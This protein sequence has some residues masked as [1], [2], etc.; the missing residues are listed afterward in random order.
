VSAVIKFCTLSKSSRSLS[1]PRLKTERRVFILATI[2]HF[3]DDIAVRQATETAQ[4]SSD[5]PKEEHTS[6]TETDQEESVEFEIDVDTPCCGP[7]KCHSEASCG[8]RVFDATT[9][10]LARLIP[11][12]GC[13]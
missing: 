5:F 12:L 3:K 9:T 8:N 13:I 7:S 6:C 11:G 2:N 10:A 4:S 1:P